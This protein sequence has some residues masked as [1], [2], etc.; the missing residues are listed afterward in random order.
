MNE[1]DIKLQG[2]LE[3]Y[4]YKFDK[5]EISYLRHDLNPINNTPSYV[6]ME[7]GV[8]RLEIA[9][10]LLHLDLCG[11]NEY[12]IDSK[13]KYEQEGMP[14]GVN[15]KFTFKTTEVWHILR[16]ALQEELWRASYFELAKPYLEVRRKVDSMEEVTYEELFLSVGESKLGSRKDFDEIMQDCFN[17]VYSYEELKKI[18]EY[19]EKELLKQCKP[20]SDASKGKRLYWV[21]H[22]FV[23]VGVFGGEKTKEYSF[24]YDWY[25]AC[26]RACDLGKGF[27]GSIGNDKYQKVKQWIKA[28]EKHLEKLN[29]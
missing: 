22:K 29:A 20:N 6:D 9:K 17:E 4:G 14:K 18:V 7:R 21:Y 3:E 15:K 24:L 19:E 28:Y 13:I 26:G 25:V 1:I 5:K 2:L 8:V 27:S 16:C 10:F 12:K 11:E 23:D